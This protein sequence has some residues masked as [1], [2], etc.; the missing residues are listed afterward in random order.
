[1]RTVPIVPT[2]PLLRRGIGAIVF[3]VSFPLFAQD[4]PAKPIRWII[5]FGPG[6]IFERAARIAV[7][8]MSKTLGQPIVV[9]TRPGAG[10][11]IGTEYVAKQA[12]ADGYTMLMGLT[13]LLTFKLFVKELRFDPMKDLVPVALLFD[14]QVFI[15]ANSKQPFSTFP[16][17]ISYARANPGK[18]N[19]GTSGTQSYPE[20]MFQAM[21]MRFGISLVQIVYKDGTTAAQAGL[22]ADH[23]Q[24]SIGGQ[25]QT[26]GGISTGNL[27]ALTVSGDRRVASLPDVPAATEIGYP[28]LIP[29]WYSIHVAAATPKPIID[30]LG[31]AA[32]GALQHP[33]TRALFE[34]NYFRI[35]ALGPEQAARQIAAEEEIY[36]GIAR[37]AGIQP[38]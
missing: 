25:A 17:F 20:L 4:F 11:L 16:E 14:S 27:K 9:E 21:Q 2:V 35:I 29:S 30:R 34:K 38:Q 7:P 26:L 24:L 12:P 8:E 5:P 33:E 15:L 28:D 31:R 10:A 22:L 37:K 36:R 18:L 3:T 13:N 32:L 1:M 23:V 19:Y 6:T